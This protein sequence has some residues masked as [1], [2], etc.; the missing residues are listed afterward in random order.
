VSEAGGRILRILVIVFMV[1]S[2]AATVGLSYYYNN[3]VV[4]LRK[5]SETKE[6]FVELKDTLESIKDELANISSSYRETLDRLLVELN[7]SVAILV[8]D[9]GNGTIERHKVYFTVDV[10]NTVFH[11]TVSVA[12]VEYQYFESLQDVFITSIN[13]VSQKQVSETSGYYWMLYVNFRLSPHGAMNTKVYDGDII[14]W[15]YTYVSWG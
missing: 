10:N 5:Y 7:R 12:D 1:W 8:I 11:L 4:L 14:I 13:G 2:V 9:Y 6:K 15:N 3:Y